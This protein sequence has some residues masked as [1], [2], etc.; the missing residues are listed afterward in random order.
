MKRFLGEFKL[1]EGSDFLGQIPA[2]KPHRFRGANKV[3]SPAT[4]LESTMLPSK[5]NVFG[6]DTIAPV[7]VRNLL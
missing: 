1:R 2:V 7:R 3:Q 4:V 6:A 5:I